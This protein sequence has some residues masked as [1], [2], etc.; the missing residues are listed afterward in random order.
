MQIIHIITVTHVEVE[1]HELPRVQFGDY[2]L[3]A[4]NADAAWAQIKGCVGV[5]DA[6]EVWAHQLTAPLRITPQTGFN[7]H[8]SF[9]EYLHWSRVQESYALI[10]RGKV[11][12]QEHQ[13]KR[14]EAALLSAQASSRT[15]AVHQGGRV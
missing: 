13:D 9:N 5:A 1:P 8:E 4:E 11:S 12:L 2:I 6:S 15:F 14:L 10:Q 7:R 3:Q